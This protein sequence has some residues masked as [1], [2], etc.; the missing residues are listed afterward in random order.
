MRRGLSIRMLIGLSV[1]LVLGVAAHLLFAGTPALDAFIRYVT[2][3]AGKIFLRLLFMLVIPLI[4]S[5][6]ALGVAGLGDLGRLGRIGL[7]TL[8]YTVVVSA[9]RGADRRRPGE[10]VPARRG[11]SPEIRE[12]LSPQAS[13]VPPAAPASGATGIDFLVNLVP[14]QLDQG[15]GRGRHAR[16]DG[17]LAAARHRPRV[18]PHRARAPLRGG[19]RRVSTTS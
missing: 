12:R 9:H 5:A 3:P 16:G 2:E 11:I 19:A 8:A 14:Q 18:D 17:V 4:V 7:K 6:L 10:P 13:A 15:D 1:G